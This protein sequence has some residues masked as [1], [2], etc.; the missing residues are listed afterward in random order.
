[1]HSSCLLDELGSFTFHCDESLYASLRRNTHSHSLAC[2]IR[3]AYDHETFCLAESADSTDDDDELP[4]S[5]WPVALSTGSA[6]VQ[7][8]EK[9]IDQ[10]EPFKGVLLIL[11]IRKIASEVTWGDFLNEWTS[12]SAE[13]GS[14]LRTKGH[15]DF[16]DCACTFWPHG[17]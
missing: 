11:T 13:N 16:V 2:Q 1:V 3:E 14:F 8:Y 17:T 15:D 7:L 12:V 9:G 5:C 4:I 6:H 10:M